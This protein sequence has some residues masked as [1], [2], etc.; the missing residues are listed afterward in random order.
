R[1]TTTNTNGFFSFGEIIPGAYRIGFGVPAGGYVPTTADLGTDDS[2]DSDYGPMGLTPVFAVQSADT[3][4]TFD[5]GYWL[6]TRIGSLVWDDTNG[7]GLQDTGEPGISGV[8]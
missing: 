5:A 8:S 1:T 4:L 7:N 3:I 2:A 6:A